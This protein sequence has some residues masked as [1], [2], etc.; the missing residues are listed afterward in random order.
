MKLELAI[1]KGQESAKKVARELEVDFDEIGGIVTPAIR[2]VRTRNNSVSSTPPIPVAPFSV[3]NSKQEPV[4]APA[5]V[6]TG[7]KNSPVDEMVATENHA[8]APPPLKSSYNGGS[9]SDYRNSGPNRANDRSGHAFA[10]NDSDRRQSHFLAEQHQDRRTDPIKLAMAMSARSLK[11]PKS[12][13]S[14]GPNE[15]ILDYIQEYKLA[16]CEY[17][18]STSMQKDFFYKP[19][20]TS[21][22]PLI[23]YRTK[24]KDVFTVEDAVN[25]MVKCYNTPER[26]ARVHTYLKS[27][28]FTS[29]RFDEKLDTCY[30]L[31]RIIPVVRNSLCCSFLRESRL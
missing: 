1:M 26:Q 22:E 13:F 10:N 2:R 16:I 20:R 30:A 31:L 24:E 21:S 29:F 14:G 17:D 3:I 18:L 27:L 9:S 7:I 25:I 28:R 19:F 8:L 12:Q 5:K 6:S 4:V 15:N 11:D 23:F